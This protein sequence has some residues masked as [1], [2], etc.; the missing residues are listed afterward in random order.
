LYE[1]RGHVQS[2]KR[3]YDGNVPLQAYAMAIL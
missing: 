2:G 1:R 3:S